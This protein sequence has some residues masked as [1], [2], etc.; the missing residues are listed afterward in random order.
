[1]VKEQSGTQL[2]A[3]SDDGILSRHGTAR[4]GT[5]RHCT[6]LHG[7]RSGRALRSAAEPPSGQPLAVD[8]WV[9]LNTDDPV[10]VRTPEGRIFTGSVDI[11]VG[12]LVYLLD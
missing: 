4:H 9:H 8:D 12:R 1:V 5:A 3:T 7:T 2:F 11:S 6:A 10:I